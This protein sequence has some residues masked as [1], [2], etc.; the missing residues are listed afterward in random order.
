MAMLDSSIHTELLVRREI[1]FIRGARQ[2]CLPTFL[3]G[4]NDA[5]NPKESSEAE[6]QKSSERIKTK[7]PMQ[8]IASSLFVKPSMAKSMFPERFRP[9]FDPG[10]S[11]I[12]AAPARMA[13]KLI[14]VKPA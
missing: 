12:D 3:R 10:I 1:D 2:L 13:A 7:G 11:L 9:Y 5:F 14:F 4:D 6:R 8:K